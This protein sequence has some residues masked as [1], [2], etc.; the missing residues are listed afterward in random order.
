MNPRTLPAALA[1]VIAGAWNVRAQAQVSETA[2]AVLKQSILASGTVNFSGLKSIVEFQNG[3]KVRG[4]QEQVYEKAPGK[5]RW[6]VIAPEDQKGQLCIRNGQV[7]WEYFPD[8]GRAVR[9]ELPPLEEL[10]AFRLSGLESLC[11]RMRIQ[12]LG[13]ESI[14]GRPAHVVFVAASQGMPVKKTWIDTSYHLPLKTQIFDCQGRI[15]RSVYYTA[16]NYQPQYVDGMFDFTPPGGCVVQ[17]APPPP[18][19]VTLRV[20]EKSVG[21]RAAIPRYLPP[22]YQLQA[23]RVPLP[24]QGKQVVLWLPFSNGVDTFSIFQRPVGAPAPPGTSGNS[25]EWRL[26]DFSFLLVGPL[27]PDEMKQIRDSVKF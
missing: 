2:L 7:Q 10:R 14:A 3:V 19:R 25:L 18:K 4:Y 5:R 26:G 12:Y 15:A 21:F 9:R 20:A 16:I 23:D 24:P 1:L 11:K 8:Q 6:A 22:G 17:N 13:T 27:P